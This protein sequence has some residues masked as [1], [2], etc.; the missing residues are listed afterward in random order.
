[1]YDLVQ[2]TNTIP[3]SGSTVWFVVTPNVGIEDQP[4]NG[5]QATIAILAQFLRAD[6]VAAQHGVW[7]F[8]WQRPPSLHTLV[9][10]QAVNSIPAWV[11]PGVAGRSSLIG[12]VSNWATTATGQGGYIVSGDYWQR[13]GG[14][15]KV[16]VTMATATTVYVEVWD[17]NTHQLVARN[18]VPPTN[19][20]A[21]VFIPF[22]VPQ[23]AP[24]ISAYAGLGPFRI[25]P[26][27][28]VPGQSLEIRIWSPGGALGSFYSVGLAR[29]TQD[30]STSPNG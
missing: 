7:A 3:V 28:G 19:R 18:E 13:F 11:A 4:V 22:S 8:R 24:P 2:G 16:R 15:Y 14:S 6:L 23:Q 1:V 17:N 21:T 12:P 26:V 30:L 29:T 10:P 9:F 5:A 20:K 25:Q 27:P